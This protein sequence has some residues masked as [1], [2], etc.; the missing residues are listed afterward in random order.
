LS[1]LTICQEAASELG[2]RQPQ[3]VVGSS[4]LTA[5]ILFRLANAA[6]KHLMGY[7]D[8]QALIVEK[9]HTSLATQVQ[10][11]A[12]PDDY[13]RM[14]YNVEI[15]NTTTSQKFL[16]PTKQR[17]WR[18]LDSGI[19]TAAYP[20]YWRLIG[21]QLNI[22]PVMT[23]GQTIVFEYITKNWCESSGG[24]AQ[25]AFEADTDVALIREDLI[26]LEVIWRFR[27]SKGFAQYAE[28][29]ETSEREKEK[30]ASRD[31]GTGRGRAENT[32][33]TTPTPPSWSGSIDG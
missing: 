7:H 6:G 14:I 32:N 24:D 17:H 31:R 3:T 30:A 25:E 21:G 13:D 23:A 15:W 10:T 2:L 22:L 27:K 11:G 19:L 1:L 4:D 29:L 8:W 16:G 28:D 20:G 12:I 18:S 33:Y 26:L 5:Q 9:S